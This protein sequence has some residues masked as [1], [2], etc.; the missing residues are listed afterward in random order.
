M[1]LI[2]SAAVLLLLVF[3]L[4]AHPQQVGAQVFTP[5]FM[6]PT[7]GEG[8]G[9]Y[10]LKTDPGDFGIEG[11]IWRGT[12]SGYDLAFRGGVLDVG[13]A[14]ITLGAQL[15]NPLILGTEP[16]DL[17]FTAGAQGIVGDRSAIGI[18]A[19]LSVGATFAEGNVA[20]TPYL[21]PRIGLVD[22]FR[23]D[24][25]QL[26]VLADIGV[27]V[28]FDTGLNFRIGIPLGQ[29]SVTDWGVGLTF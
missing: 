16:L 9:V 2:S 21:H 8:V 3:S 5:T 27:A 24:N 13:D 6:P 19:G 12:A 11:R 14:A 28:M 20:I 4:F 26:E 18:D 17:A 1:K 22:G 23:S 7:G 25:L 29:P 10:L 15:R